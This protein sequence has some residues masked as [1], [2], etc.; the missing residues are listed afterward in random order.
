VSTTPHTPAPGESAARQTT[1]REFFA[2][3]FRRR[4]LILGLFLVVSATVVIVTLATPTVYT[5]SG[6]VLVTRGERESALTGRVQIL[7]EWEQDL[8][9]E[10]AKVHSIA[11]LDSARTF[12]AVRAERTGRKSPAIDSRRVDV[13]V[14]GKSNVIAIGYDDANPEVAQEVC[15]AMLTAYVAARQERSSAETDRMF[16]AQI[17]SIRHQID[18]RM[19]QR[20]AIATHTGVNDAVEATRTWT[21]QLANIE[22]RCNDTAADLAEA[23]STLNAMR[24]LQKHPDYDLPSLAG[25]NSPSDAAIVQFK[26]KIADQQAHVAQLR[27]RYR[28]DSAEVQNALE[29]LET[30]QALLR[31]EVAQRVL[32]GETRVKQL[33]ARLAAFERDRAEMRDR[34]ER[35]PGDQKSL[36]ELDTAIKTL[37]ARNEE[38][39]RARDQARIMSNVSPGVQVT[40]LNPAG[41]ATPKNSRDIVRMLLAPA[42]SL[43]VGVGLAFFVDG[44]DITVRTAGQAEAYLDLP[45]LATLPERR[46]RRR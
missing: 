21:G 36:D 40:L 27:E 10:V 18:S 33:Q 43:V 31:K 38:Y 2:V 25:E 45:V 11:V 4:W 5:S 24:E 28:D 22:Q 17:D 8:A 34:L 6:R 46:T 9:S 19:A 26:Q 23:Q 41:P 15:D 29:T 1:L 35:L 39:V 32:L 20:Q 14:M 30:L 13:E 7:N 16:A 37:R 3:I 12:L 42:F 44:L